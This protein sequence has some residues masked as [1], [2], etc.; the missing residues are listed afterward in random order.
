MDVWFLLL[1]ASADD[2]AYPH[3]KKGDQ[4]YGSDDCIPLLMDDS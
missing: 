4:Q 2:G 1:A 3:M